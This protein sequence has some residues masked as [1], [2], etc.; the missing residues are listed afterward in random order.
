MAQ[1]ERRRKEPINKRQRSEQLTK[2]L[3]ST[4][5]TSF[6][7][8]HLLSASPFNPSIWFALL[9]FSFGRSH[10]LGAQPLTHPKRKEG[11]P[12]EFH[13]PQLISFHLNFFCF[14]LFAERWAGPAPLTHSKRKRNSNSFINCLREN[15]NS[16]HSLDC[17]LGPP[18]L[19]KRSKT[20]NSS[21]SKE[22][23]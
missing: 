10:W 3:H 18:P 5:Q 22:K 15:S 21:H 13:N 17:S 11:K 23:N 8:F 9:V 4:K 6:P 1:R 14:L 19:R 12:K 16:F 2:Q 7:L 20:I